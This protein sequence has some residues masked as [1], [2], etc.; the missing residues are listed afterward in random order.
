VAK[1]RT[2][3]NMGKRKVA[4]SLSAPEARRVAV[5]GD[6]NK[7]SA[8]THAMKKDENGVWH[9]NAMLHAGRYEYRFFVDGQWWNDPKNDQIC[10]NSFGTQNNVL[11]VHAHGGASTLM[12]CNET[13]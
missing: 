6:F 7:W 3:T 13:L 11:D 2:K 12:K 8:D 9:R 4:F 5:S 1:K 10:W